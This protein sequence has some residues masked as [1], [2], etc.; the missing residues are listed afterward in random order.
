M[1]RSSEYLSAVER[2]T[3][4]LDEHVDFFCK[5]IE[6]LQQGKRKK[7]QFIDEKILPVITRR[8]IQA[9]KKSEDSYPL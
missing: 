2:I 4:I 7:A 3:E 8:L 9:I 5:R 1:N 6:Y